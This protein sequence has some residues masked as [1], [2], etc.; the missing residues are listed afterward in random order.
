MIAVTEV[1][2]VVSQILEFRAEMDRLEEEGMDDIAFRG[3]ESWNQT[4]RAFLKAEQDYRC[5][6]DK[7]LGFGVD[8]P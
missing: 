5:A 4:W 1:E 6:V 2:A 7:L 8:E 3:T